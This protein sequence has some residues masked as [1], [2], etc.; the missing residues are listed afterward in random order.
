MSDR[1]RIVQLAVA[2]LIG[3]LLG[4]GGYALAANS[5]GNTIRACV[6]RS[7]VLLIEDRCGRGETALS[8]NQRGPAGPPGATGATGATGAIGPVGPKGPAGQNAVSAWETVDGNGKLVSGTDLGI[9]HVGAGSYEITKH[10]GGRICAIQVTADNNS[11]GFAGPPILASV[12][13]GFPV[14]IIY[15]T[16]NDGTAIDDGFSVSIQC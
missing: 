3:A 16:N 12:A 2:V 15:L 14:P 6:T 13:N 10:A 11:T 1:A 8:W 7:R 4:G 9:E 5:T